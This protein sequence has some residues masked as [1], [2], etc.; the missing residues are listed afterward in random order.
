MK[1]YERQ[2]FTNPYIDYVRNKYIYEYDM[3]DAGFS[4]IK[5]NKLLKEKKISYISNLNKKEKNVYIGNILKYQQDISK[6]ISEN[7]KKIRRIFLESNNLEEGNIISIK[8]DA[9]FTDKICRKLV[10]TNNIEFRLKNRYTSFY[11]FNKLEIYFSNDL[12]SIK[13]AS[14]KFSMENDLI[15]YLKLILKLLERNEKTILYKK[16]IELKEK[17]IF[18][19]LDIESYREIESGSFKLDFNINKQNIYLEEIEGELFNRL[20]ISYNFFN[21]ILQLFK[22][23]I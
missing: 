10:L 14:K 8:K 20:D 7:F 18:G 3:K 11:K 21:I 5:E 19:E 17:Y 4:I 12:I 23:A 13:G 1:I 9:I 15:R 6:I 16:L 22:Y 2:S